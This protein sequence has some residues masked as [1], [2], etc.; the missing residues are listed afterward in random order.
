MK[1]KVNR[2]TLVSISAAIL[3]FIAFV[4]VYLKHEQFTP[5]GISLLVVL[6]VCALN[7]LLFGLY[8]RLSKRA[9]ALELKFLKLIWIGLSMCL[10]L[11]SVAV[12]LVLVSL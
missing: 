11:I 12:V 10:I 6:L 7:A 8:K 1:F 9:G 4:Y 3:S 5:M 2:N